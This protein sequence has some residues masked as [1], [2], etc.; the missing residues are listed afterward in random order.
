MIPIEFKESNK[1]FLKPDS[2]TD[3]ECGSLFVHQN[4]THIISCWKLSF[5]ERIQILFTGIIWLWVCGSKQPPI[6]LDCKSPF[7]EEK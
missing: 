7:E 5:K 3:K 1:K 2:M 4:E 6:S